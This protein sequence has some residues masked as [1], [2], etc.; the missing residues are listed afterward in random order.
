MFE[1]LLLELQLGDVLLL[2]VDVGAHL[3]QVELEILLFLGD[4]LILLLSVRYV[5]VHLADVISCPLVLL[6]L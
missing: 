1:R 4:D 2:H 3:L 5:E 6:A